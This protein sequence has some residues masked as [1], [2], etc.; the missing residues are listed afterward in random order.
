MNI[1]LFELFRNLVSALTDYPQITREREIE[2]EKE[3][4]GEKERE[5]VTRV[6]IPG[7]LF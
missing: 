5:R 4:E 2:R 6:N 1:R 3:R 7:S